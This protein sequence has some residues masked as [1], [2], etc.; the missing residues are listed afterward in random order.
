ML[1]FESA[2]I[3]ENDDKMNFSSTR[4]KSDLVLTTNNKTEVL[5]DGLATFFFLQ[6]FSNEM[7]IHDSR[8]HSS[9]LNFFLFI[10]E[11]PIPCCDSI[12]RKMDCSSP[13]SVFVGIESVQVTPI[14]LDYIT[15]IKKW[16]IYLVLCLCMKDSLERNSQPTINVNASLYSIKNESHHLQWN[17]FRINKLEIT[18]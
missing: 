15:G 2:D 6:W 7:H 5:L 16:E 1:L 4:V 12:K 18:K 17:Y 14:Q 11:P 8:N 3:L 13:Q 10:S 9:L